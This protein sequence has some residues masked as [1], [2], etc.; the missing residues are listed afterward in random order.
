MLP[1]G[2]ARD[3]GVS[4]LK[5]LSIAAEKQRW[6]TPQ[7]LAL[8]E[9]KLHMTLP[10]LIRFNIFLNLGNAPFCFSVSHRK[11]KRLFLSALGVSVVNFR[12]KVT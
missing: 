8:Q 10:M 6:K 12:V 2:L 5:H 7:Q 9:F 11:A 1:Q 4:E 3:T